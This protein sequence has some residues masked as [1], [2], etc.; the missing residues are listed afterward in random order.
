MPPKKKKLTE[1]LKRA[2]DTLIVQEVRLLQLEQACTPSFVI[3][4]ISRSIQEAKKQISDL[5]L[6][7]TERERGSFL[8]GAFLQSLDEQIE[9]TTE[10]RRNRCLR[11]VHV[12][13]FDEEGSCCTDFP[14]GEACVH[15]IGCLIDRQTP[16]IHCKKFAQRRGGISLQDYLGEMTLLYGLRDMFEE[17]EEIWDYLTK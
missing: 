16:G 8:K 15:G 6:P 1:P 4:D 12:Q 5:A 10:L 2:I 14:L 11:C 13:Y 9:R 7:M 3:Q 17:L